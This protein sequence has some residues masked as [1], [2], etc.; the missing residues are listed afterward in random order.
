MERRRKMSRKKNKGRGGEGK[1]GKLKE[2]K[3]YSEISINTV[4][5]FIPTQN[6][7]HGKEEINHYHVKMNSSESCMYD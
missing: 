6:C 3:L 4:H 2:K 5:S 7:M 1:G